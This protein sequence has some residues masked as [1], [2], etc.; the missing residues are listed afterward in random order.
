LPGSGVDRTVAGLAA[1]SPGRPPKRLPARLGHGLGLKTQTEPVP[2]RQ[3]ES[4]EF[5]SR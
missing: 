2:S 1:Q 3:T 4:P 5:D